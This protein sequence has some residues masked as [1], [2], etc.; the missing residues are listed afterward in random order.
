MLDTHIRV[1]RVNILSDF[2][3]DGKG[4]YS[5]LMICSGKSQNF[6]KIIQI[7]LLIMIYNEFGSHSNPQPA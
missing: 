6:E 5:K 4:K 7:L 1:E 2:S 3:Q